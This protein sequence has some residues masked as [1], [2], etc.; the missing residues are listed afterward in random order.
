MHALDQIMSN[1][2]NNNCGSIEGGQMRLT[3]VSFTK[4]KQ[5]IFGKAKPQKTGAIDKKLA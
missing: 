3:N 4:G 1:V 2:N 5:G